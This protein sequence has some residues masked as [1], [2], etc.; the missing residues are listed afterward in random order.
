MVRGVDTDENKQ[1]LILNLI[2]YAKKQGIKIL[3]EGVQTRDEMIKL[4]EFGVDYMQGNYLALP[5][6]TPS[7]VSESVKKE[8]IDANA[9]FS[10]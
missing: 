2:S 3:A 8:L 6:F 5:M 10:S 7:P 4:V 9:K 1:E